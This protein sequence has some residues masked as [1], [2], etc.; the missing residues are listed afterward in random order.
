MDNENVYLG[1]N[2]LK[3]A[4]LSAVWLF[5]DTALVLVVMFRDAELSHGF[6]I[7]MATGGISME[8]SNFAHP[9]VIEH[10]SK[11]HFRMF[12]FSHLF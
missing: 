10:F 5:S 1:A 12:S 6:P 3:S 4:Q 11:D 7:S 2:L 9:T 8:E